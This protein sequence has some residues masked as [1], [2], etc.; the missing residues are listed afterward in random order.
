MYYCNDLVSAYTTLYKEVEVATMGLLLENC[1][2]NLAHKVSMSLS[3]FWT[4]NNT[5]SGLVL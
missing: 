3:N 5:I 4:K 1:G 2:E